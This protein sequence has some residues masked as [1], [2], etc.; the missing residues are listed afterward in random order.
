MDSMAFEQTAAAVDL[1]RERQE[2]LAI[3]AE[4]RNAAG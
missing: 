4:I 3:S 1:E 2:W